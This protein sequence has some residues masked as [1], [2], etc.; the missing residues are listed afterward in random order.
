MLH[1]CKGDH[2]FKTVP[3]STKEYQ[4]VPN[5]NVQFTTALEKIEVK[6]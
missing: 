6:I 1:K 4:R 2:L 3:K 5:S